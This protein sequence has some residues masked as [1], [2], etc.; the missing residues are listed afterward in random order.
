ME[1]DASEFTIGSTLSQAGRSVAFYFKMLS[2]SEKNHSFDEK[3]AQAVVK[4][5]KRWRHYLMIRLFQLITEQKSVSFMFDN[6]RFGKV[7]NQKIQRWLLELSCFKYNITYRAGKENGVA[8]T[9]SRLCGSIS[10]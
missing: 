10:A 5:L 4:S 3:E 6:K 1:A 7:Q 8:E 2:K 9:M